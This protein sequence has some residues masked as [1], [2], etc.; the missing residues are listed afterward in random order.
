VVSIDGEAVSA[1]FTYAPEPETKSRLLMLPMNVATI[2]A[3]AGKK[4]AF[5][6]WREVYRDGFIGNPIMKRKARQHDEPYMSAL[7][8]LW[9]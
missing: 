1:A 5:R 3:A 2:L 4:Q 9:H 7:E 6:T 8:N